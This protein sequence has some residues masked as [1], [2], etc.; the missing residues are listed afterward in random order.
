MSLEWPCYL[1]EDV[2]SNTKKLTN[3]SYHE[4]IELAY[5]GATVIHPKTIKPLQNKD[6]P[7]YVKSFKHPSIPGS[8][9]NENT[10]DD[11]KIPSYIFRA[12]QVL[13]SIFT[14]DYSFVNEKVLSCARRSSQTLG[15]RGIFS[16]C[17]AWAIGLSHKS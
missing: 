11:S 9:I 3:I 17:G 6:I 12:N 15:I 14:R 1:L 10:A 16:R 4:A 8:L 2:I 7:L 5:Y 13:Y